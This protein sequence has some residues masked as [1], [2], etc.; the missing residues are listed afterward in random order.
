MPLFGTPLKRQAPV[1]WIAKDD[2]LPVLSNTT[3]ELTSFGDTAGLDLPNLKAG[4][5]E[6]DLDLQLEMLVAEVAQFDLSTGSQ[7]GETQDDLDSQLKE[8][9]AEVNQLET[10]LPAEGHSVVL[11]GDFYDCLMTEEL[12]KES[13]IPLPEALASDA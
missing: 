6:D 4:L 11:P 9:I 7:L 2:G 3:L 12:D 10:N 1:V 8:L 5:V 13:T